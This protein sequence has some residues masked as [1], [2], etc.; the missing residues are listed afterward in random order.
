MPTLAAGVA[1][2]LAAVSWRLG[3]HASPI[4][5]VT[6]AR[7]MQQGSVHHQDN[8]DQLRKTAGATTQTIS[9]YPNHHLPV[10]E[11]GAGIVE[12]FSDVWAA[13]LVGKSPE[14]AA[15]TA[16]GPRTPTAVVQAQGC[17]QPGQPPPILSTQIDTWWNR[18]AALV[19][20]KTGVEM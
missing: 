20:H 11:L 12:S 18:H 3:A 15:G 16:S 17:P 1:T 19:R 6:Y 7:A 8:A 13:A 9:M 10:L 5:D 14:L 2:P 4:Q